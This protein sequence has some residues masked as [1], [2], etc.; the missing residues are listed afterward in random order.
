MSLGL[1]VLVVV[2]YAGLLMVLAAML[3]VLRTSYRIPMVRKVL[4][5]IRFEVG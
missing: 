1:V 5:M 4:S 3:F 2:W